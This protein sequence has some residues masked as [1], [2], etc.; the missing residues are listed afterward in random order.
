MVMK[1]PVKYLLLFVVLAS[2]SMLACQSR[3]EKC[4][5]HYID[6]EGYSYEEACDQCDAEEDAYFESTAR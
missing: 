4:K 2:A 1:N 5:K 3:Y 6:E